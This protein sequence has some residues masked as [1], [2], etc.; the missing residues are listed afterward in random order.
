MDALSFSLVLFSA[1]LHAAWNV[2]ARRAA[3]NF[4]VM[5][6]AILIGGTATIPVAVLF[7]QPGDFEPS[8]LK[9][10]IATGL[11][12]AAYFFALGRA[13]RY[14]SIHVVYPISR[15]IGVLG[16][17]LVDLFWFRA[18]LSSLGTTAVAAILVGSCL[19][20]LAGSRVDP[21]RE[22]RFRG[23]LYAVLTGSVLVFGFAIGKTMAHAMSPALYTT[24]MYFFCSLVLLPIGFGKVK[25]SEG[26][27]GWSWFIGLS[28][29][30]S[31]LLILVAFR[32]SHASYVIAI[33]ESSVAMASIAGFFFLGEKTPP[34]RAAGIALIL[35]GAVL[36][37]FS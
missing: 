18:K 23:T 32:F 27:W 34:A 16:M 10:T 12:L 19:V 13:Y 36:L 1:F 25:R 22:T 35:L 17:A 28:S 5:S 37:K 24:G 33:R 21:N 15:G 30:L 8:N 2:L 14:A 9:Y 26:H 20:T 7:N 29:W 31:Y 3:G 11:L 6:R 4:T